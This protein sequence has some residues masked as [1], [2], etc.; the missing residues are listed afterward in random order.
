MLTSMTAMT[1]SSGTWPRHRAKARAR[2]AARKNITRAAQQ[3]RDKL[4]SKKL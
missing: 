2:R 4:Y 1:R 3:E